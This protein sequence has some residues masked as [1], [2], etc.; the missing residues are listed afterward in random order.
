MNMAAHYITP[1]AEALRKLDNNQ[2]DLNYYKVFALE[3]IGT[4]G[5]EANELI[6]GNYQEFRNE[7]SD[8]FSITCDE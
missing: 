3:G 1:I 2:Y 7:V 6:T 4:W 5:I 8:N